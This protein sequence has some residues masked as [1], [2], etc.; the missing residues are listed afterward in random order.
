M[1]VASG[2]ATRGVA[3]PIV[4]VAAVLVASLSLLALQ[5]ATVHVRLEADERSRVEGQLVASTALASARVTYRADLDTLADGG[6]I[7]WPTVVRP[8]GWSWRAEAV[9]T[10]A[11]IRLAAV[12][13]QR[14]AAGVLLAAHRASLLLVRDAADTVRVLGLRPRF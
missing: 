12:A 7:D 13:E 8:D 11:V 3:L 4:L 9:R 2:N 10:G 1:M 14:S 6:R 5:A